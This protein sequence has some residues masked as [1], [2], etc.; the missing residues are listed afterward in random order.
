MRFHGFRRHNSPEIDASRRSE[1]I[2]AAEKVFAQV[3]F[4]EATVRQI[5]KEANSNVCSVSYYFGGKDGLY[6]A[7]F[8][9]IA[10]VRLE[11]VKQF[12]DEIQKTDSK[13]D[14]KNQLVTFLNKMFD[15]QKSSPHIFR[16]IHQEM[17][18]GLPRARPIVEKYMVGTHQMIYGVFE[19]GQKK[20]FIR[21]DLDPRLITLAIMGM[22]IFFLQNIIVN[23]DLF[24]TRQVAEERLLKQ[25]IQS[26]FFDGVLT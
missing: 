22:N 16:M 12:V 7:V 5:C 25:T 6:Q 10:Q 15:E 11:M 2:Q 17:A 1:I 13:E 3:G 4:K 26:I 14:Y 20:G 21:S 24:I 19:F 18:L 23:P 8:E 9:H